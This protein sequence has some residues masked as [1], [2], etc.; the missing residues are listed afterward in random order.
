MVMDQESVTY[1]ESG[2]LQKVYTTPPLIFSLQTIFSQV[3][4]TNF[5]YLPTMY[6]FG[7]FDWQ[8]IFTNNNPATQ[9]LKVAV[10][11]PQINTDVISVQIGSGTSCEIRSIN[12][13]FITIKY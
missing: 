9:D 4:E 12:V 13:P 3:I 11:Y 8:N 6:G 10:Y 7:G 2:V 1:S 5:T